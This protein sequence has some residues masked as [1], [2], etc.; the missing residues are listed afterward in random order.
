MERY[1]AV[2]HK[3]TKSEVWGL[4]VPWAVPACRRHAQLQSKPPLSGQFQ[5]LSKD[6]PPRVNRI[7]MVEASIKSTSDQTEN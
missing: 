4:S 3:N 2:V 6:V 5:S 7:R 1:C